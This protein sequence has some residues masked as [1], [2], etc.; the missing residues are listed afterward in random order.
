MLLTILT[1][2]VSLAVLGVAA[3]FLVLSAMRIA[4]LFGLS[5]LVI[6][7]TIVAAGTSAP[8]IAVSVMA[9]LNGQGD[10]SVGNVIGSNIF[11]LGFILGLTALLRPQKVSKKMVYRDG[12]VLA[13][14]TFLVFF[15][16]L[17]QYIGR[18]EGVILLLC[19]VAYTSYLFIKKEP[20]E[21]E[22]DDDHEKGTWLDVLKFVLLLG[23]L[24]GSSHFV[25][26]SAV[27]LARSA[28]LSEWAIGVTIVA[29]GTSLPEI[30]TSV[31]AALRGKH[32]IAL[33]NVLGSDIFN[34]FGIIGVSALIAP[35]NLG[36]GTAILGIPDN[37]FSTGVLVLTVLVTLL[38]LRT[39]WR[40][41]RLEGGILLAFAIGR[42]AFEL[43]A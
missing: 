38:M 17:N 21:E 32:G 4:R 16:M 6:G 12:A 37:L 1:L 2:V 35:L 31:A 20:L 10:L 34:V 41:S 3:H 5:E 24:V 11:N 39:G 25:L 15:M 26:E 8:E 28:G 23:V 40:L 43:L 18:I 33:G 30:A 36:S 7:L 9:A 14:S 13:A 27:S 22:P 29:A 19:L 42:M